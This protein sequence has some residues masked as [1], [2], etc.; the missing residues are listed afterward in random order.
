LCLI[1][2]AGDGPGESYYEIGGVSVADEEEE[3]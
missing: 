2:D 1:T 3:A